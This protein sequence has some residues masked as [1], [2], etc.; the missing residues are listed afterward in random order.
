[1]TCVFMCTC[2]YNS[3]SFY[4]LVLKIFLKRLCVCVCVSLCAQ[5]QGESLPM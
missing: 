3:Y 1:M 5:E 2:I 4:S